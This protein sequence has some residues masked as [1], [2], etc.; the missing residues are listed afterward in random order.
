MTRHRAIRSPRF[1]SHNGLPGDY[2]HDFLIITVLFGSD[3][4]IVKALDPWPGR[5]NVQTGSNSA[6]PGTSG[7]ARH[8]QIGTLTRRITKCPGTCVRR[9]CSRGVSRLGP[10]FGHPQAGDGKLMEGTIPRSFALSQWLST[11]EPIQAPK[12][13]H[14]DLRTCTIAQEA[15]NRSEP[16]I[17]MRLRLRR[18]EKEGVWC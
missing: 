12:C 10:T 5:S 14:T 15:I 2:G 6:A 4:L 17:P 7:W 8:V 16:P 11:P 1:E 9:G 13:C 3:K 18:L